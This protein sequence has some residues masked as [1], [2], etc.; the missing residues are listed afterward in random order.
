MQGKGQIVDTK[1]LRMKILGYDQDSQCNLR[2]TEV[3]RS[4][5]FRADM[6]HV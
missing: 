3:N 5:Y 4:R 1:R 6:G 2:S